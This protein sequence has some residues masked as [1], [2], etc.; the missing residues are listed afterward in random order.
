MAS[1]SPA[2]ATGGPGQE[3]E[4][5]ERTKNRCSAGIDRSVFGA[6]DGK[7]HRLIGARVQSV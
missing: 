2:T 7:M 4:Q 6:L 5:L 3:L 1:Q